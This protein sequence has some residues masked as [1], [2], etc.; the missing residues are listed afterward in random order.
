MSATYFTFI[1]KY[2][3]KTT[4]EHVIKMVTLNVACNES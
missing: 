1:L 2:T 4:M 3:F